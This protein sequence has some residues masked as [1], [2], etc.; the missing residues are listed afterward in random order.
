M[1]YE[2]LKANR[3]NQACLCLYFLPFASSESQ[4]LESQ[5]EI[6]VELFKTALLIK[7]YCL[8]FFSV[9]NILGAVLFELSLSDIPNG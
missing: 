7:K 8:L 1:N 9:P 2:I 6:K 3:I 5:V 4:L